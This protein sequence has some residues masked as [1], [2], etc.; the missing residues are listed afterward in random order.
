MTV[1]AV[2]ASEKDKKVANNSA[3]QDVEPTETVTKAANNAGTKRK[4]GAALADNAKVAS[5]PSAKRQLSSSISISSEDA[6]AKPASVG[7]PAAKSSES[8]DESDIDDKEDEVEEKINKAASPEPI[9]KAKIAS[10]QAAS[11]SKAK[12]E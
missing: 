4:A 8:D 10:V 9:K 3:A 5:P 7:S 11:E 1:L 6:S 12:V 2:R